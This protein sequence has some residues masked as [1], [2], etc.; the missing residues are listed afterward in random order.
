MPYYCSG[1]PH[2]TST[3]VPEGSRALAGIGCHFMAQWM[4]RRTETFTQMGGEGATWSGIAPFTNEGHVFANLGDG[5]YFHSGILAI[6]QAVTSGASITYKVLYN[7][8]V[9]MTGGQPLDGKLTPEMVT[10]QL[11]QEGVAPIYL[12]SDTPDAYRKGDLAPGVIVRDREHIDNVMETLR[13]A[14]GCS[15]IVYVQTC[16]AEKRRR[17]KRGLIEDPAKRV[18]IN[19][20]VCEGCGDCSDQSNCMS[21]EP[22]ET[23]FG[24]K[25]RINQSTC[26][27]DF[28]CLKGFCPS[29]VTIHGGQLR[30]RAVAAGA[31]TPD[32]PEP[33]I[34]DIGDRPWNIAIAG[35]GGTGVLTIGAILGMAAHIDG[36]APMILDM[37]GLAQKG[38]AVL[39]HVRLGH[40]S[41]D[42]TSPRIATGSAD[43][44]IAA[45]GVVAASS[46]GITVCDAERTHAVV[47]TTL[48]P[49]ADFIAHRDLDFKAGS[50]EQAIRSRVGPD[51][52][53]VDFGRAGEA[54]IGDAIA[55]NIMMTGYAWQCGLIPLERAAIEK[56]IELNGVAVA[57]NLAAFAWGRR[58]AADPGSAERMAAGPASVKTLDGMTLEEVIDHRSR[59]LTAYQGAPLASR[60]RSL[61]ERARA[62]A[63]GAGLDDSLPLSVAR[64]YARIL[65]YKDEYEVARLLT[66]ETFQ[67]QIDRQ[68]EGR[69]R[70]SF[71]LA[72]PFIP[73]TAAD[74]RPKK[75]EFGRW[76][77]PVLRA[78][79]RMKGIRGTRWDLFG[80]T[81][82]RRLERALIDEYEALVPR[83]LT[84]LAPDNATTIRAL[85]DLFDEVR[86]FGPVKRDSV[87]RMHDRQTA[88]LKEIDDPTVGTVTRSA[89]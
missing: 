83:L 13:G 42:V 74:G 64:T 44:L 51:A 77:M 75:R 12:L 23:A 80:Y 53:F 56:A 63:S 41:Q 62:A 39:S 15:A 27:K 48:S 46:D 49:V 36:K 86:G 87:A 69:Y 7:D 30:S 2:N 81:S 67:A 33:E 72:P 16:A 10:H 9:A 11:H 76:I 65:A 31:S 35:I 24:R 45:D 18:V 5:T 6:R 40:V 58:L 22:L 29:F 38:G 47:N 66:D 32:L 60:Y 1:C 52:H 34:P 25:R 17:R 59:H 70:V 55:T 21:I 26:N 68:F 28:S 84:Q 79:A 82:E 73:G 50:V 43:L 19:A 61:V 89:A 37:A 8:A 88:L 4:D 20:A 14:P 3:R 71:N 78:L 54:V 57:T 85:V